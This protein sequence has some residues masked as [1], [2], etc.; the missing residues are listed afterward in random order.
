MSKSNQTQSPKPATHA[1]EAPFVFTTAA[2]DDDAFALR[3]RDDSMVDSAAPFSFPV[4]SIIV[5]DPSVTA[6]PGDH[7]VVRLKE[8]Q[9]AI[10]RQLDFDGENHFLKPLNPLYPVA[11]L[12]L[13]AR[14]VGVVVQV[15][16]TVWRR[17]R[18]DIAE[19]I[20]P[21]VVL[22]PEVAHAHN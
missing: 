17:P 20:A 8:A 2:V 6:A 5:V 9:E 7:V 16:K 10:F 22:A 14:I 13:D 1:T 11:P 12:P 18:V 4:D 3:I 19:Q 21:P 15:Q